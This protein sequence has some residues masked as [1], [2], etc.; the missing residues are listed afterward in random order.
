M[1]PIHLR[2]VPPPA[3]T[4]D[5]TAFFSSI[6]SWLRPEN[7]L[8]L[9]IRSGTNFTV[10]SHFCKKSIGVDIDRLFFKTR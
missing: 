3:E 8:E 6:F 5:H 7:Y 4:F 2:N 1:Q 9:G 10:L